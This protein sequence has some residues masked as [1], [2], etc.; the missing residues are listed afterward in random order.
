VAAGLDP[1]S[2]RKVTADMMRAAGALIGDRPDR[3]PKATLTSLATPGGITEVGLK[4]LEEANALAPWRDAMAAAVAKLQA[5][6]R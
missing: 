2:A 3:D 5:L 6:G 4:T 1:E